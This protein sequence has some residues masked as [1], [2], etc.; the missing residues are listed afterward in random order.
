MKKTVSQ[1]GF[2][3]EQ[4]EM[5]IQQ[6]YNTMGIYPCNLLNWISNISLHC[7][8][9]NIRQ[10]IA[11]NVPKKTFQEITN[12]ICGLAL[13]NYKTKFLSNIRGCLTKCRNSQVHKSPCVVGFKLQPFKIVTNALK[14]KDY[15]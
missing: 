2:D 11:S 12:T 10:G 4:N 15:T 8:I 6:V 1:A 3:Q 14:N 5:Y 13:E 7:L 9:R